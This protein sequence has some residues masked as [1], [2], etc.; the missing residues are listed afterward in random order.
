MPASYFSANVLHA[1]GKKRR[2]NKHA[3]GK[4]RKH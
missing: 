4:K 2:F 3:N 1:S